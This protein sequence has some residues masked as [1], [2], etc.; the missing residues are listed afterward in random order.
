ML[1]ERGEIEQI[2]SADIETQFVDGNLPAKLR[3]KS[4]AEGKVLQPEVSYVLEEIVVAESQSRI[5]IV[6]SICRIAARAR[7]IRVGMLRRP[8][9][10]HKTLM[11]KRYACG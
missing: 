10:V 11:D 2:L 3:R 8:D 4:V 9:I 7:K 6:G 5:V 1:L